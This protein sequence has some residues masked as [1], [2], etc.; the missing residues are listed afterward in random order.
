NLRYSYQPAGIAYVNSVEQVSEIVKVGYDLGYIV[1]ARS[2]GVHRNVHFPVRSP[3]WFLCGRRT[4][5]EGRLNRLDLSNLAYFAMDQPAAIATVASGLR[6]GQV[7]NHLNE[8]GRALPHATDAYVGWG[9]QTG[10]I[11]SKLTGRSVSGMFN[12]TSVNSTPVPSP[13]LE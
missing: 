13:E 5:W 11:T 12:R 3:N 8:W 4:R 10:T 2:G 7:A 9:G 6:I 1:V